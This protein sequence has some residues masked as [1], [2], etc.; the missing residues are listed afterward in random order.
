MALQPMKYKDW[1][2]DFMVI[3]TAHEQNEYFN[4]VFKALEML[5]PKFEGKLMHLGFGMVNLA[6]GKMSSRT[7]NIITGIGLIEKS[8]ELVQEL[9]KER[10]SLSEIEKNEIAYK[11]GIGAVKYS[12]L[13]T[14]PFQ[15][16]KFS[17]EESLSFE[18]DSG[19]YLQYTYARALSII[20]GVS[21]EETKALSEHIFTNQEEEDIV[22]ILYKFPEVVHEAGL[23]LSPY[24][25]C[26]CLFDLAQKFNTFYRK[27]K[28]LGAET[29]EIKVSRIFLTKA[30]VQVLR[31]GL[32]LLGID[33]LEKM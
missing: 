31:N 22:R 30:V 6:S 27:H 5:D 8:I 21:I 20:K 3:M 4:V 19:P 26:N 32:E 2:F 7:G 10:E 29:E 13:K 15:D 23:S 9:V 17:F 28:V 18:G 12:L 14:N 16:V 33:V 11:V 25:I 1:P 24:L